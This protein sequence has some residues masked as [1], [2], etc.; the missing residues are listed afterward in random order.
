MFTWSHLPTL[1]SVGRGQQLCGET[2]SLSPIGDTP[3]RSGAACPTLGVRAA[4]RHMYAVP[5]RSN[6][7]H[8]RCQRWGQHQGRMAHAGARQGALEVD[9]P[10]PSSHAPPRHPPR[11]VSRPRR[12]RPCDARRRSSVAS[13]GN[14]CRAPGKPQES[15]LGQTGGSETAFQWCDLVV[16]VPGQ[17]TGLSC[18]VQP[19]YVPRFESLVSSPLGRCPKGAN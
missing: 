16:G 19:L 14:T 4:H 11:T 7:R 15:Q 17:R 18:T 10:K 9:L 5:R 12:S 8:D 1:G 3:T 2:G 6:R 13:A